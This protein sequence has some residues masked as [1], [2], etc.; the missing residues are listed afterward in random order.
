MSSTETSAVGNASPEVDEGLLCAN[1]GSP[2][3]LSSLL[4]AVR[5]GKSLLVEDIETSI[6][7]VL[8]PVL[9]HRT[10]LKVCVCTLSL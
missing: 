3:L 2:S 5:E 8:D 1:A 6:D 9:C 7:P 4:L 10:F